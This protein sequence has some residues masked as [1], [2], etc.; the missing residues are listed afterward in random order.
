MQYE[1]NLQAVGVG[2]QIEALC[3]AGRVD[4]GQCR[5]RTLDLRLG[6]RAG[7]FESNPERVSNQ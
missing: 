3:P 7:S 4:I 5:G 6:S 1:E 2:K